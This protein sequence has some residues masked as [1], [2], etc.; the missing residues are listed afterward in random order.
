MRRAKQQ[1][2]AFTLLQSLA[3]TGVCL[4]PS[5]SSGLFV[6]VCCATHNCLRRSGSKHQL[7]VCRCTISRTTDTIPFRIVVRALA[8]LFTTT[9][10]ASMPAGA[11]SRTPKT[12]SLY[13]GP[14]HQRHGCRCTI[15]YAKDTIPLCI[16]FRAMGFVADQEILQHIVYDFSDVAMMDVLRPSIEEAAHVTSEE[17]ALDWIGRRIAPP[18]MA[19]AKRIS[20]ARDVLQKELLPHIGIG[21]LLESKKAYFLGYMVHRMLLVALGRQ[22]QSDRDNYAVKRLRM[23]GPL[24]ADLFRCGLLLHQRDLIS[25]GKGRRFSSQQANRSPLFAGCSSAR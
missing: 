2:V 3:P 25:Y 8:S 5:A 7:H 20:Y 9:N 18:F 15:P 12:P 22:P 24:M 21:E 13:S 11:R 17:L 23:A 14:S 4:R 19:K 16:V 6:C 10:T 1:E